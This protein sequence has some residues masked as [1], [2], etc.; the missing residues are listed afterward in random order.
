MSDDLFVFSDEP[1][2]TGQT[3]DETWDI[4]VVDDDN[5]VHDA[6]TFALKDSTVLGKSLRF[7]HAYS[8]DEAIDFL[9][10]NSHI[11]VILMDAVMETDNAG[12]EAVKV[13]REELLMEDVRIILRTG[14]PGQIPEFDSIS[15]YDINDYKTKSELTRSKLLTALTTAVRSWEQLRRVQNSRIGLEKI[16]EASNQFIAARG[17]KTFAEGVISQMA[18]LLN[19][20]PEG[21]VC[22]S[23]GLSEE[24]SETP[25]YGSY[26]DDELY[27][28]AAAGN[29]S[30][31]I[32]KKVVTLK[33][34][35]IIE[36]IRSAINEQKTI[37]AQDSLTVFFRET[38][39][40]VY[41]IYIASPTPLKQIDQYLL[42]VFC[43]NI[44]LCA[45]NIELVNRLKRQAWE[46]QILH[47][48]NMTALMEEIDR[49]SKDPC[50]GNDLLLLVDIA[51]FSQINDLL[52]HE[53]GDEILK[54]LARKLKETFSDKIYISRIS[55]DIFG[56]VGPKQ[57][58]TENI[59]HELKTLEIE[60]PDGARDLSLYIG[61]TKL[62]AKDVPASSHLH[63][64]F[65]SLK[66]SKERGEIIYYN[67]DIGKQIRDQ[68]Q[69][70]HDL[71]KAMF[72]EQLFLAYQPQAS[73]TDNGVY[74]FEALL[75]WKRPDGT[76]IPPDRFIPLAE[77]SGL[78]V[79]LGEWV[80]RQALSDLKRIH[81]EGY[82]G[83]KIAVNVSVI[84]LQHPDFL[85]VL[86]EI[87]PESGISPDQ[88]EL[89]IT[90]SVSILSLEHILRL[91]GEIRSRGISI[92]IDDFGTGYSS[93]STID[94]WPVDRIKIDKS[95]IQSMDEHGGRIVDMVIPLGEQLSMQIL[96]EGVET[97][98]QLEK[99]RNLHCSEIQGYYLS[100][101]LPLQNLLVWLKERTGK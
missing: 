84:Q 66:K 17:L 44:S 81:S 60:T 14:Q 94:R 43:T 1:E 2:S 82:P 46:D 92:A 3:V 86:D 53:Y 63:N 9:K 101:P 61:V 71:K 45:S 68:I 28:I 85:K 26:E 13:I 74:S 75:R 48:P 19:L 22:A 4:L 36:S 11:A 20:E 31:M 87:V 76:F 65:F 51:S 93:L 41:A 54:S 37:L 32:D 83:M 23:G 33:D 7:F 10:K 57:I 5:D 35:R 96:A 39:G 56:L 100:R 79:S 88:L 47:I 95:F 73:V 99:L 78:I 80:L 6:T 55:A 27:V 25:A 38:S 21:I 18:G 62:C 77:Q 8:A 69:T 59:L 15:K 89:E 29:Y 70:L 40:R 16:V 30:R 34:Q 67:E 12:L 90:E 52:G 58:L 98:E 49:R 97:K 24:D 42:E 64:A 72:T 50:T 91:L